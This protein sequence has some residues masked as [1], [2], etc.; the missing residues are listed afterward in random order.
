MFNIRKI[1]KETIIDG[2]P[3]KPGKP[4]EELERELGINDI[5]KLASNE[6]PCGT[7]ESAKKAIIETIDKLY[8]YP[9]GESFLFKSA[10]AKHHSVDY[11]TIITGNAT[12]E[13]LQIAMITFL[14]QG[15]NVISSEHSFL[16][17][18]QMT[19]IA[20]GIYKQAPMK[21]MRYDLDAIYKLI[22]DKTKLIV[23][24]N[25][26]NPTG[27]I[28]YDKEVRNF[29]DKVPENIA[30]IFDE[31]Y[32]GFVES[33]EYPDSLKLQKE[34]PNKP[35]ITMRTFSKLYGLAGLRVG[36]AIA[37]PEIIKYFN[38]VRGPFNINMLAQAAGIACVNNTDHAKKSKELCVTEKKY[39]YQEYK[40]LGV[41]V[42]PTEANFILVKIDD[43]YDG[44]KIVDSLLRAGIIVRPMGAWGFNDN[45]MRITIGTHEQNVKLI[46]ALEKIFEKTAPKTNGAS[47][48][49]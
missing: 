20:G 42:T 14:N 10:I 43:K 40:R 4:I 32:E 26:N 16:R 48:H 11:N 22:D 45:Y 46:N 9:D 13:L 30:I 2:V 41:E 15:D 7:P 36:Y 24:A 33:E 25:P 47:S 27:T 44:Q 21:N 18:G 34:Y 12:D 17:Y 5:A 28:V 29:L 1:V 38:I 49:A 39:L 31:A 35:I 3:Y 6:N 8:L 37:N 19:K 23:I